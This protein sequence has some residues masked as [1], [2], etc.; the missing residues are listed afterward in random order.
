MVNHKI[1][2]SSLA[3]AG[4]SSHLTNILKRIY[5]GIRINGK[6]PFLNG[7]MQGSPTSPLEFNIY[8]DKLLKTLSE[9]RKQIF[10]FADDLATMTLNLQDL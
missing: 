6:E 3:N 5:F 8:I 2:F 9:I 4:Y 7:I 10:A 1:L